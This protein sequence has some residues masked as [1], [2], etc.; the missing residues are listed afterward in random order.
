MNALILVYVN[1]HVLWAS[2]CLCACVVCVWGYRVFM[3]NVQCDRLIISGI[4]HNA[5]PLPTRIRF[6]LAIYH[7]MALLRSSIKFLKFPH[8]MI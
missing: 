6:M 4:R 1:D 7:L 8:N 2:V 3:Q 5:L